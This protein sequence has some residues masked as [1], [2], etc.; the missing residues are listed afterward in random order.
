MD[1]V[2]E[3]KSN[4]DVFKSS[5]HKSNKYSE[6]ESFCPSSSSEEFEENLNSDNESGFASSRKSFKQSLNLSKRSKSPRREFSPSIDE[7]F[8]TENLTIK[9]S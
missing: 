6:K 1:T 5:L 3:E 4:F 9:V 2:E 7:D 8:N